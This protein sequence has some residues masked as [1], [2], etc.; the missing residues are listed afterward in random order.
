MRYEFEL[1]FLPISE[2]KMY[3]YW[4]KRP[5]LTERAKKIRQDIILCSPAMSFNNDSG[6]LRLRLIV[7]YHCQS[8][9]NKNGTIKR[10][11]HSNFRKLFID[12][13]TAK[14]GIDDAHIWEEHFYKVANEERNFTK[15]IIEEV[16]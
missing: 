12:A 7:Y 15:I 14:M 11:D 6:K 1:P 5:E 4:Q 9:L 3:V 8:W 10:K 16:F 13:L 2:N